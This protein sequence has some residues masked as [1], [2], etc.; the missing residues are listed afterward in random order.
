MMKSKSTLQLSKIYTLFLDCSGMF[1]EG[2]G[3]V[4]GKSV[5]GF[6]GGL[7]NFFGTCLGGLGTILE[8]FQVLFETCF[9][10]KQTDQDVQETIVFL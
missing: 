7:G 8:C 5:D 9:G 10:V 6:G 2:L 1:W 3:N 4:L